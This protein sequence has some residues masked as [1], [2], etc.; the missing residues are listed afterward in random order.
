MAHLRD[1]L[2]IPVDRLDMINQWLTDPNNELINQMLKVVERYGGPAEINRKA[3]QAREL[4][5][6]LARLNDEKSPYVKDLDWLTEQ[7]DKGSFVSMEEY[8]S[9][10]LGDSKKAVGLNKENAVNLE[11]SALQYFPWLIAEAKQSIARRELMPGRYIRV[12]N[13]AEQASDQ[14]DILAV[15]AAM[16]IIGA[17]YV[18]TL[19]TKGTDG[20]NCHLGG[21]ATI[22]GYFGGVGQP[23]HYPIKW[24]DEFLH[25]YT[26]YGI[27]Q[28]LNINPGTVLV[29]Y[30]MNKLGI[31]NEF[32]I[33]VFMGN[34]NPFAIFW[35]LMTARLFARDDGTTSL[36]G[37][38]LSNSVNNQTI[39]QANAV[40]KALDFE[41]NVR[42]EHHI[43]ETWKSIVCQPYNRREELLEIAAEVPNIAAKHEGGDPAAEQAVEH[44]S[45]IL[46]YFIAKSDV[47]AQ[48]LMPAL[49]MNYLEKHNSVNLTADALVRSGIGVVCAWNLH[50]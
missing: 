17:S 31:D 6:L 34:D 49:E 32:K 18:E 33:S 22:T 8:Y 41:K 35:T 25:Y 20:S 21:P 47:E 4:G 13:M 24:L 39:R 46:D 28:V 50:R 10:V 36:I 11:I 16:Q 27:K 14:G 5:N 7:R 40:R 19:D 29:G 12:R 42:F 9:R 3:S 45:D 43:T 37:F 26:T 1:A 15:A 30:L 2:K 48:G 38:N 23:N 44:P